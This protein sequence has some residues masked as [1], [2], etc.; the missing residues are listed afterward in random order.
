MNN[1]LEWRNNL[2]K[3]EGYFD[4]LIAN[5][6]F[7]YIP[8]YITFIV[9]R[10]FEVMFNSKIFL[11]CAVPTTMGIILYP[12]YQLIYFKGLWGNERKNVI[13]YLKKAFNQITIHPIKFSNEFLQNE[14][15]QYI[16]FINAKDY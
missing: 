8:N 3:L 2:I 14:V 6:D 15:N 4:I 12:R 7:Y 13:N 9:F 1:N 10:I 11:E 16:F 5:S